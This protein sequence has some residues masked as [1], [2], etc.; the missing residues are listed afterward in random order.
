MA[1]E[2]R[3]RQQVREEPQREPQ[4]GAHLVMQALVRE[5][6]E[7][8]FGYPGGAILPVYDALPYYPIHHVLVRHEQSAAFAADGYARAT[9]KV[10]VCMATSGPGATNLVTGIANAMMDSIPIVAIT[11]QVPQSV[12]G[13]D[14]F[15]ETDITGIT[16]PITKYNMVIRSVEEIGPAIQ[17]AFYLARSG[18]PG[19]VLIDIPKDVQLAKGYLAPRQEL[20]LPG[21]RPTIVPHRRQIRRAAELIRQAKRP[22]I[23]AGHGILVSGATEE[24]VRFAERTQIPVGLTLLGISGFPASHPLCLG[25]VG[26]H[27]HAHA[28]RAIHEAD[29]IIGIGMR[30][31]DRV[32]GRP[33]EFAPNAKIIHIDID[34]A[35]IG[36]VLKT[37]VPVVGDAR[38][39]LRLLLEELE[40]LEHDD[41]LSLIRSWYRPIRTE[42]SGPNGI[43]QPQYVIARLHAL[44]EGRA[45]V[46]TDVGQHQMWTAQLY[47]CDIPQQWISSGGLGAMGFG[48]PSAMGAAIG[49]PEAEVWA[50][51]GDGGVQM[52]LN[53][54]ATIVDEQLNVKVAIIN[55]GYLGMVRQWQQLF[56]NRNYSETPIS[57]PDYVL[58]GQA[59]RMAARRVTRPG[60]VDEAILWARSFRGPALIEFVVNQE[61]NVFPMIPSGGTFRDMIDEYQVEGEW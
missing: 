49:R 24:L 46:T 51:V 30:F 50:V 58:L 27:G 52:T 60:E 61:E 53:E 14:A 31:D 35:E 56:H 8:I 28:N 17:K 39:A 7:V 13:M 55:N 54:F 45:I 10:G 32:T 4:L 34:P 57:S 22:L 38:E 59:Y 3:E 41:W 18:R 25:M 11:G 37:E 12:I 2:T 48:V 36:K 43:L 23:L 6:V 33:S 16:L 47:K 42:P 15:Q 40:P 21:Y 44:T 5:G 26:M 19:P 1:I 9:G 29:L 20:H